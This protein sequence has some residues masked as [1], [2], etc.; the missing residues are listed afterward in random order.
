MVMLLSIWSSGGDGKWWHG[1][2]EVERVARASEEGQSGLGLLQKFGMGN[3][4]VPALKVFDIMPER[5]MFLN[6]AIL[7]GGL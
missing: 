7:F 1:C 5:K 6:F 2:R 4:F 3:N